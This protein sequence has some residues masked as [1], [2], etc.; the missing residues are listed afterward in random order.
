[1]EEAGSKGAKI[2]ILGETFNTLYTKEHCR[3]NAENLQEPEK[4]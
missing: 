4:C 1:L 2:S 3:N